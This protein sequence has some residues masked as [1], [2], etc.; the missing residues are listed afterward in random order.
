MIG[1]ILT[2]FILYEK[3][4]INSRNICNN[5]IDAESLEKDFNNDI[6]KF[7]EIISNG[8]TEPISSFSNNEGKIIKIEII[9]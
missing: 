7:Y 6:T 5:I 2:H 8:Y 4:K 9:D 3:H 1:I